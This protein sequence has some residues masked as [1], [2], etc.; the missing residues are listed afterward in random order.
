MLSPK[1]MGDQCQDRHPVPYVQ[2][3][4]PAQSDGGAYGRYARNRFHAYDRQENR[5]GGFEPVLRTPMPWRHKTEMPY[6]E[7]LQRERELGDLQ[8][9]LH[10]RTITQ[11]FR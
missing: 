10:Y 1:Q 7:Y 9:Y 11:I 4:S 6:D 2:R 3:T 5:R 8:T